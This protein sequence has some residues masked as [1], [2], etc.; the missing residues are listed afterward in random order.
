MTSFLEHPGFK[1][2]L[3]LGLSP[4]GFAVAG[5]GPLFARGWITDPGD[6][7]VIARGAT[8]DQVRELGQVDDAPFSRVKRVLLFDGQIEVLDGWFPEIWDVDGLIDDSDVIEGVRFVRLAV[9]AQTKKLLR[10]PRDELHLK[11][12]AA[13]GWVG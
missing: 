13:H 2:L 4:E 1:L 11:V 5:S 3:G 7:D 9:I 12:L 8:W 10:R 6:V